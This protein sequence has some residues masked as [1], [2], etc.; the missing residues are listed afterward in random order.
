MLEPLLIIVLLPIAL[1]SLLVLFGVAYFLRWLIMS[2][3]LIIVALF[4]L[5]EYGYW[6]ILPF[7]GSV[8][9]FGKAFGAWE[10]DD[11]PDTKPPK[12]KDKEN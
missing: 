3:V 1:L 5:Y 10:V 11:K 7:V 8:Y 4:V 2:G 12:N 6:A 9:F